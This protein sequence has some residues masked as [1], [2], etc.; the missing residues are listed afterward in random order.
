MEGW[1]ATRGPVGEE[2]LRPKRPRAGDAKLG[3]DQLRLPASVAERLDKVHLERG[4][5]V[6]EVIRRAVETRP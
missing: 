4:P 2:R 1:L 5:P 6:N 3:D